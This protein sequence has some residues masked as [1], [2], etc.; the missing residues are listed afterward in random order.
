MD[1]SVFE[2]DLSAWLSWTSDILYVASFCLAL[3]VVVLVSCMVAQSVT[4]M[5][6]SDAAKRR[7]HLAH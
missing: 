1:T 4:A 7:A 5:G 3:F 2:L 6:H